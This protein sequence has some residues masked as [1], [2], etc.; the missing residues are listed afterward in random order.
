MGFL[1]YFVRSSYSDILSSNFK[2]RIE[3][4]NLNFNI[5][6]ILWIIYFLSLSTLYIAYLLFM[7]ASA[8]YNILYI[9]RRCIVYIPA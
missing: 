1:L 5:I 8:D 4:H 7:E 6:N 3:F 9:V 2:V